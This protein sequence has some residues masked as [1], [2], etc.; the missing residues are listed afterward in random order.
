VQRVAPSQSYR[1]P[2]WLF[3]LLAVAIVLIVTLP[4]ILWLHWSWLWA[5][6]VGINTATFLLYGYDKASAGGG[7]RV[8]E[9]VLHGAELLGGTPAALVAQRLFHH[10]TRKT[11][12]QMR[13]WLIVAVQVVFVAC[14]WWWGW[15]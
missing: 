5:W 11:S 10:K 4:L 7:R 6:L 8:P 1:S 9:T 12:Y 13:F 3:S 2:Y 15:V 14:I